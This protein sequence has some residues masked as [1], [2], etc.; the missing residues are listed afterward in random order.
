MP[1]LSAK[2]LVFQHLDPFSSALTPK[3]LRI[4][5][6]YKDAPRTDSA[7]Y[8][9][10]AMV[11]PEMGIYACIAEGSKDILLQCCPRTQN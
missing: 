11:Q 7:L 4:I 1:S 6:L 9:D 10:G 3:G 2:L 5:S 8:R